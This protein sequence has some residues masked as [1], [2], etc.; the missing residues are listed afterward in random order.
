MLFKLVRGCGT[1]VSRRSA[2]LSL[3]CTHNDWS[4]VHNRTK[5]FHLIDGGAE[6][7]LFGLMGSG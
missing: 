5:L 2:V 1:S 4:K 3:D 7:L 6:V